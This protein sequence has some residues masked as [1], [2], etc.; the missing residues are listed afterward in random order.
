MARLDDL[1]RTLQDQVG[2]KFFIQKI[3]LTAATA[4]STVIPATDVYG[5]TVPAG[6]T[7]V[8]IPVGTDIYYELREAGS[9]TA[10]TDTSGARPGCYVV[11]KVQ[12]LTTMLGAAGGNT[13]L[14]PGADKKIDIFPVSNG[15]AL[16][17]WMS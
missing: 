17:F 1:Q 7:L 13:T 5:N 8:I 11:N 4:V 16:I 2:R 9:V 6:A 10:I 15:F 14:K 3:T 12:E